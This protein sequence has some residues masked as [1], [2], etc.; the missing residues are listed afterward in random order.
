MVRIRLDTTASEPSEQLDQA[1][2]CLRE[3]G[4]KVRR[5]SRSLRA[6]L[7]VPDEDQETALA[8]LQAANIPV[9]VLPE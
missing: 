7:D 8:A 6:W 5:R 2:K 1:R 9:I 4:V 3:A